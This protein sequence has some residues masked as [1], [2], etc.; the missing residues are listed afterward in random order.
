MRKAA[1]SIFGALQIAGTAVQV[2]T[3]SEQRVRTGPGYD[4]WDCRRAHNQ[5]NNPYMQPAQT[6]EGLNIENFGFSGFGFSGRYYVVAFLRGIL[7]AC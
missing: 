2:A 6:L 4:R 5:C 1:I 3:A 7:P